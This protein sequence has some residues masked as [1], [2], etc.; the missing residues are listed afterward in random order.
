MTTNADVARLA[1]SGRDGESATG[2]MSTRS[3]TGNRWAPSTGRLPYRLAEILA[4]RFERGAVDQV[5]YSY[6]TI[7]AWR[8]C[9]T[10]IVPDVSY[11]V[12]TSGKH[13]SQLWRLPTLRSIPRDAGMDEYLQILDGFAVYQRGTYSSTPL[14][15]ELVAEGGVR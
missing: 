5:I 11:S 9:G 10:W 6:G 14:W 13:Q 8:D 3:T 12:T 15:R 7:I 2:D 1:L 4:A